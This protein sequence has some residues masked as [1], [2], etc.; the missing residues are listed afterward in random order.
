MRT[1]LALLLLTG[2]GAS[3][4][5]SHGDTDAGRDD[6]P[7]V[8]ADAPE[9]MP[10][11]WWREAVCFGP[12]WLPRGIPALCD[13]TPVPADRADVWCDLRDVRDG[14]AALV[15]WAECLA[16]TF[17]AVPAAAAR[18][19]WVRDCAPPRGLCSPCAGRHVHLGRFAQQL[20][21][22]AANTG[23]CWPAAPVGDTVGP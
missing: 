10:D 16:Y 11:Q 21:Q 1:I 12:G 18:A 4:P 23:T 2:C 13:A 5:M 22:A 17:G 19:T 20:V 6:A 7:T 8:E 14:P 15:P 9:A 3:A